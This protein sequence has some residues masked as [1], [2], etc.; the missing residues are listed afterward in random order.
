M[1]SPSTQGETAHLAPAR[2]TFAVVAMVVLALG[3]AGLAG[4]V[5]ARAATITLPDMKILVPTNLISI[6][7]DPTSGHKLLRYTHIT[8][9]AGTGPFEIDPSYNSATGV[10]SFV[11]ALYG[12]SGPGVWALDHTVPLAINGVFENPADYRFPLT[13]FTL[14]DVNGDGTIGAVVSTSPKAEYCITGDNRV[15][16]VPNTPAQ[17]YPPASN[18]TD[19]TKPLGWSVGWGD[20]YDQTD[21]GQPIDLNGVADGTYILRATV[22]PQHVLTESDAT[23]NV[24]DTVLTITGNAVSTGAQTRPTVVPPG[25]ALL[26]PTQGATV[27][28]TVNLTATASAT[29][30]A[31]I[32]SVQYLL[33]GNP[34]GGPQ[35]VLPYGYVWTVGSTPPGNHRL[36][37][38]VTD[39]AG[40]IGTSPVVTVTVPASTPPGGLAIDQNVSKAGRG[41]ITTAA[42]STSVAGETLVAFVGSDG[43]ST[44]GSQSVTITGGGLSWRRVRQANS[45]YG[46]AEVW[47]ASAPNVLS[48]VTVIST[49]ARAN[50]DQQLNVLSFVGSAGVGASAGASAGTGAPTVN[51]TA[52]SAGS[53]SYAVGEDWDRALARTV[54]SGQAIINQWVDATTGD[55][56]WAQARTAASSSA[57]EIVTLNDTAPTT[58]R[59]N[60]AA[61]EVIPS[62]AAPPPPPPPPDVTPPSATV[63]NPANGQTVSGATPVAATASD[64]VAVASVQFLLDGQPLGNPVTAPPYAIAWDTTLT[65]NA[66]HTVAAR[67]TDTSGNVGTSTTVTVTVQNPAPPMT[68]FILQAQ[69][70]VHGHGTA[71]TP[72]FSTA[73]A[74]EVLVAFV[75]SDGPLA[76]GAQSVAVSGAGLTW[77]LVKRA[78]AQYGDAE[79]WTATAPAVLTNV[80]V[81]SRPAR[82]GYDQDLTVIAM[83]GT[84]GVGASVS[85]SAASGAPGLNVTTTKAAS[86]VLAVGNDWDTATARTLP[87]GLVMLDQWPDTRTG[88]TFW[89]E[90]TNQTTGAAGTVV[91]IGA[92]APTGDRWNMVA[93]EL[94]GDDD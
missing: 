52:T 4:S 48:A 50:Y 74:G 38:Q 91:H 24:T 18:C 58:D 46:D 51:L 3:V 43:P 13:R 90:Y 62:G 12:S 1:I 82:S 84:L 23:N 10:S 31:T 8:E 78:N 66:V 27:A 21:S 14:N 41:T 7:V 76:S 75:G 57:G 85:G 26:S 19:P 54:G 20:Q 63:T 87:T 11:Q 17:T 25:V 81:R 36:S 34:L 30:P 71:T 88:D 53:L 15:A 9:D 40:N 5:T 6:G 77:T 65:A 73:M 42:F 89:S 83:E 59:W 86:L 32:S 67:A 39:S 16:D 49:P 55:T 60:F 22:D 92:T 28:D 35:T 64:N 29:A 68:C 94:K 33:D 79:V 37:A 56:F 70:S 93:I 2:T 47:T 61:V 72:S 69:R 80:T 44:T 45:Q